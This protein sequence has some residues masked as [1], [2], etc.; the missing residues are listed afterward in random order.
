[1]KYRAD[2]D[3]LRSIAVIPVILFHLEYAWICG[4]YFGVDVFF[5]ISGFLITTI[6]INDITTNSFSMKNFWFRR[7]RRILPAIITVTFTTLLVAPFFIFKGDIISLAKDALSAL[8]SYANIYFML[9]FG[10]YWGS[11]AESSFFLHAWSLSVEEQFYIIYPLLLFILYKYKQSITK[12]LIA[13]IFVSL[14]AYLYG[15][16]YYPINTFYLLPTRAWELASGGLLAVILV[17]E[18]TIDISNSFKSYLAILGFILILSS[19]FVFTGNNDG[20][21]LS[22]ILPVLGTVLI[23]GFS[24]RYNFIGKLLSTKL[25]VYIGKISYSLYLWHWPIIVLFRTSSLNRIPLEQIRVITVGLTIILS[26]LSYNLVENKTRKW[27]YTHKFVLGFMVFVVGFIFLL[28]SPIINKVYKTDFNNTKFYGRYYN[29]HPEAYNKQSSLDEYSKKNDSRQEGIIAPNP[30]NKYKDSYKNGGII[31]SCTSGNPQIVVLGDSHGAMWAKAIDEIANKEHRKVTFYTAN[32]ASPFFN[33][34]D[35]EK[36]TDVRSFK[37][38]ERILYAKNFILNLK[39]WK[40]SLLIIACRW[41]GTSYESFKNMEDLIVLC[42]ELGIK[43]LIL[44]Q[45][46]QI[47]IIGKTNSAQYLTYLGFKSGHGEQYIKHAT[48]VE[49]SNTELKKRFVKY[50]NV[51]LFDVYSHFIQKSNHSYSLVIKDSDVLYYDYDHLSYQGASQLK[52]ELDTEIA[53]LI[54]NDK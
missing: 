36:Q 24:T 41:N 33:L 35:I 23:I 45:P 6:L 13:I 54:S 30:D 29:I 44:N 46:P 19:Y 38:A 40:P 7:I 8:F 28:K 5:V 37:K 47:D 43:V 50:S 49:P 20:I 34:K 22:A 2:I 51:T 17:H 15:S 27:K 32:G 21:N 53:R 12:W 14:G 26:I 4:G 1:M 25:L 3:G 18:K 11:S 48:S 10:D 16:I 31:T 39:K 9:K 52:N 42:K